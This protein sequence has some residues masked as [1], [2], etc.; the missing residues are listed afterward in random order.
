MVTSRLIRNGL[1]VLVALA[2]LPW[3][4]A[5]QSGTGG[6]G[7]GTDASKGG[8]TTPTTVT[9]SKTTT[10]T[11][12]GV[13]EQPKLQMLFIT[14]VVV[15]EDGSLIP[16][17]AVI[18]RS[19]QGRVTREGYVAA[20]G[21]FS[22]Q[23]GGSSRLGSMVPDASE[24]FH[25]FVRS[26]RAPGGVTGMGAGGTASLMGCELRASLAG[27][28]SSRVTLDGLHTMGRIDAGTIL[29][30]PIEKVRGTLVSATDLAAPK[31]AKKALERAKEAFQKSK[32]GEAEKQLKAA[33]EAYPNYAAAWAGL[34][35]VYQATQRIPEARKAYESAIAADDK[36]VH[37]Y[38]SLARLANIEQ[39]WQEA[40]DLTD[41]ALQLDP[42][43]FPE[44]YFFNAVA[45]YNLNNFEAAERSA[46]RAQRL[47]PQ[48]RIPQTYIVLANILER[49]KD[50]AG[51]AEQLQA[52]LTI[53]PQ[54]SYAPQAR[55]RLQRLEELS[56]PLA[57]RK[58]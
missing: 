21:G 34:G 47:D 8:S 24:E 38:L 35:Q 31:P 41:R 12:S 4:L 27:Y 25:D 32:L 42:V 26:G 39:K 15:M 37:P 33:L 2:F 45:H 44:G 53:A 55:T 28:R 16:S 17:G 51:A 22:F 54:S 13:P 14:G 5:Q 11:G 48:H 49:R 1:A 9:P 36:F 3:A 19:C 29:L 40:A 7:G 20:N 6:T 46:H 57:D 52:Y 43:D 50:L 10:T 18:E 58:P 56:K 30:V 23:I